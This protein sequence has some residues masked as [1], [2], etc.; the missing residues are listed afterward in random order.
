MRLHVGFTATALAIAIAVGGCG[1]TPIV[2]DKLIP[3]PDESPI[4]LDQAG[5]PIKCPVTASTVAEAYLGYEGCRA[6]LTSLEAAVVACRDQI[7]TI[8]ED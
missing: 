7:S 8:K 6:R 1:R 2:R 4:P 3:C 5:N